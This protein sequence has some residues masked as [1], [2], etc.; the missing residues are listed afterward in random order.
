MPSN[1]SLLS[2]QIQEAKREA[3]KTNNG[4]TSFQKQVLHHGGNSSS[5]TKRPIYAYNHATHA[6]NEASIRSYG[7]RPGGLG[8]PSGGQAGLG[9]FVSLPGN[10][11]P[12]FNSP[13]VNIPVF[14]AARPVHDNYYSAGVSGYFP[15]G[16]RPL[17]DAARGP[18]GDNGAYNARFP[19]TAAEAHGAKILFQNNGHT[20]VSSSPVAEA[21]LLA[22]YRRCFPGRS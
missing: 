7:L 22:E 12:A 6:G 2:R 10:Y 5:G 15:N 4:S 1:V 17:S 11:V 3:T 14:S 13:A 20:S 19:F 21:R 16:T 8:Q 18:A 9:V